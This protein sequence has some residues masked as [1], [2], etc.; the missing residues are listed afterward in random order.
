[1]PTFSNIDVSFYQYYENVGGEAGYELLGSLK[2]PAFYMYLYGP[3][4]C[5]FSTTSLLVSKFF[6]HKIYVIFALCGA[7]D[8]WL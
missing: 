7:S 3:Q 6:P 1:M 5:M 2:A 4:A 8:M